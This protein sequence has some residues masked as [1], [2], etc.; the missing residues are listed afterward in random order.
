MQSLAG[1]G[2]TVSKTKAQVSQLS[3]RLIP[4]AGATGAITSEDQPAPEPV[5]CP[6]SLPATDRESYAVRFIQH[7]PDQPVVVSLCPIEIDSYSSQRPEMG[8]AIKHGPGKRT[9]FS[10]AQRDIMIEFYNRQAVNKIRA[11]PRDVIRAME[12]AG[13]EVLTATQ[14]KSW[15][16]TYHRKN[17]NLPTHLPSAAV[18]VSQPA[19][20]MPI[21][22]LPVAVPG[23][24]ISSASIPASVSTNT[25][26]VS[27][28]AGTTPSAPVSVSVPPVLGQ[29]AYHLPL[30]Q[31]TDCL[32]NLCRHINQCSIFCCTKQCSSCHCS[33]HQ[34]ASLCNC[35]LSTPYT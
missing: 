34:W 12:Q 28:L 20:N 27:L 24:S 8:Y 30:C 5:L 26:P 15:W 1:I 14:I 21:P 9:V 4:V 7:A 35:P 33:S 18:P 13:L 31:S 10:Q 22:V 2:A 19:V 23:A 25:L 17:K 3:G 16:S 11:E 29:P 32:C 6:S